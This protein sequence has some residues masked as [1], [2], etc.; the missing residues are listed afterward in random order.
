MWAVEIAHRPRCIGTRQAEAS[1]G[2]FMCRCPMSREFFHVHSV[3]DDQDST[4]SD[5][6]SRECPATVLQTEMEEISEDQAKHLPLLRFSNC[7][8]CRP[9]QWRSQHSNPGGG[10]RGLSGQK[11][12][13]LWS[14][15]LRGT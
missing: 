5:K 3:F 1:A 14:G 2:F 4:L 12:P 13:R 8:A 15:S 11:P 6:G 9:E 7:H 10:L